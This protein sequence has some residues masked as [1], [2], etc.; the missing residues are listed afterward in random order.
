MFAKGTN[1]L[2]WDL[3]MQSY[4]RAS[5]QGHNIVACEDTKCKLGTT[6][7]VSWNYLL[8][9]YQGQTWMILLA[10]AKIQLLVMMDNHNI[11]LSFVLNNDNMTSKAL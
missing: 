6:L 8:S 1:E 4:K 7:L 9:Y 11:L 2:H 3:C 10:F 5:E